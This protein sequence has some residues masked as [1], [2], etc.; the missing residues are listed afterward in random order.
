MK[1]NF[2]KQMALSV[3][4]TANSW[5]SANGLHLGRLGGP[6]LGKSHEEA[7]GELI[8]VLLPAR[9]LDFNPALVSYTGQSISAVQ[10]DELKL[11]KF[12]NALVIRSPGGL[13]VISDS[14]ELI[15]GCVHIDL[16]ENLFLSTR[17]AMPRATDIL[18]S[19]CLLESSN[20]G[21][22]YHWC[23]DVLPTLTMLKKVSGIR[24]IAL[25]RNQDGARQSQLMQVPMYGL[26]PYFFTKPVRIK[27]FYAVSGLFPTMGSVRPELVLNY[28]Q[29][30]SD[31][32]HKGRRLYIQRTPAG[33]RKI[34]NEDIL[35]VQ[36]KARG[37]QCINPSDFTV[38]EQRAI[39]KN[40]S[41]IVS[42]HGAA[43]ANL[44]HC[45]P[46]TLVVELF[47]SSFRHYHYAFISS[48][49]SLIYKDVVSG[50]AGRLDHCADY[51]LS[52]SAFE[53]IFAIVGK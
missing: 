9:K 43:L 28:W 35:M 39:F 16:H 41:T 15:Q 34:L 30:S 14:G 8:E 44:I 40:A 51:M 10:F 24:P 45:Q 6:I 1:K 2:L 33:R 46:G 22:Y 47:G 49:F 12:R 20:S 50:C 31:Q 48:V 37:F 26:N 29:D 18:D 23:V 17:L 53:E 36:M 27:E 3:V 32:V 38:R 13:Q 42:S 21:N 52:D 19:A 4:A 7:G 11:F 5:K 25:D